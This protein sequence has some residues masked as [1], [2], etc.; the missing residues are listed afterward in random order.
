MGVVA[1]AWNVE[2]MSSVPSGRIVASM[3]TSGNE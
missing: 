3:R 1:K 2:T